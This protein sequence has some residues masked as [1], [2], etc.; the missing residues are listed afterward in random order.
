MHRERRQVGRRPGLHHLL[1]RRLRTRHFDDLRP[2]GE[3]AL[4][5]GGEALRRNAESAGDAGAARHDIADQLLA[6]RAH[7]EEM[8]R[9]RIAVEDFRNGGEIDRPVAALDLV[10]GGEAFDE[11]TQA[12]AVEIVRRRRRGPR[13]H[14]GFFD[15]AHL[16]RSS[17]PFARREC[18]A[19][20]SGMK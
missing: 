18:T 19:I 4:D 6:L 11:A 12:K 20:A 8:H 9:A 16:V 5:L 3:A 7:G 10:T 15:H 1:H 14:V 13:S 17:A 2:G